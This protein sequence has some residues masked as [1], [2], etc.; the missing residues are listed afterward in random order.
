MPLSQKS[1]V[2]GQSTTKTFRDRIPAKRTMERHGS[3]GPGSVWGLKKPGKGERG[4][5]GEGADSSTHSLG[6]GSMAEEEEEKEKEEGSQREQEGR[7]RGTPQRKNKRQSRN[8]R[9]ENH[10]LS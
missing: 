6:P 3:A 8:G 7:K 9:A 2:K 4:K 10:S 1:E 5:P